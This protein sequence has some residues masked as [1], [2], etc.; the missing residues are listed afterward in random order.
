MRRVRLF[1]K[2]LIFM[3]VAFG[4]LAAVSGGYSAWQLS[5]LMTAEHEDKA[6]AIAES[7]AGANVELILDGDATAIQA[8]IDTCMEIKGISYVLVANARGEV[9]AHTFAPAIPPAIRHAVREGQGLRQPVVQT[10][11]TGPGGSFLHVTYPV[12]A[13]EAGNVHIGMNRSGVLGLIRDSVINHQILTLGFF[14][15]CAVAAWL[16]MGTIS[17]PLIQLMEYARRVAAHDFT[18]TIDIRFDDEVGDVAHAVRSTAEELASLITRLERSVAEATEELSTTLST[19]SAIVNSMADGLMVTNESGRLLRFNPALLDIFA[20]DAADAVGRSIDD[21]LGT[22][23]AD[24]LHMAGLDAA[25]PDAQPIEHR[26][27]ELPASVGDLEFPVEISIASVQRGDERNYVIIV[28]DITERKFVEEQLREARDRLEDRV[29]DRTARLERVNRQLVGEIAERK[30]AER[31]LVAAEANYRLIFENAVEGIFRITPDG[32]CTEANP[33][34]ARIFG[35]DSPDELLAACDQLVGNSRLDVESAQEFL[36]TLRANGEV[37]NH[38]S[39]AMRRD[40]RV[41]W[42]SLNARAIRDEHGNAVHFEGSVEDI[43][44]RR[45]SEAAL[46]HRAFHDPLTA[47]PNRSLFLNHLEMAMKRTRRSP[48]YL[49]SVLYMDLDRFK[50]INDSLGHNVGDLLLCHVSQTLT[51]CV[52]DVDTVSRFGGDEFAVLIE[53]IID[54]RECI[55]I[56]KRILDEIRRPVILGGCEVLTAA[57]IGIVLLTEDYDSAED[58]LRDADTAMYRAKELGKGHFKVFNQKMHDQALRQMQM[59]NDLRQAVE[60]DGFEIH[61]QPIVAMD[62]GTVRALE[63]RIRW[64]HTEL[65]LLSPRDFLSLAEDTGLILPMGEWMMRHV[66]EQIHDWH[67]RCGLDMPVGI[68]LSARQFMQPTLPAD[69]RDVLHATGVPPRLVILEIP[70]SVLMHNLATSTALLGKLRELGVG[71]ALIDYG[72]GMSSLSHLLQFRLDAIRIHS[73]LVARIDQDAEVCAL[74]RSIVD[75]TRNIGVCG[76]A[77]GVLRRTQA[78]I[79]HQFQC[80]YVQG[81]LFGKPMPADRIPSFLHPDSAEVRSASS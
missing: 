55:K 67:E 50:I 3:L 18:A 69:I 36:V 26:T 33:A 63:A 23:L 6:L 52:R 9:L 11:N 34:L 46:K 60:H 75:L 49:F 29:R 25:E 37:R 4:V 73:G 35:Y 66:C 43:T 71:I 13:G 56:A 81:H 47:L 70:E 57:S 32:T 45:E 80:P 22:S 27:V 78:E 42:V 39:R 28:R 12:L 17:R 24:V 5:T 31:A 1:S 19:V 61:Y 30:E 41:I 58:I 72:S 21:L 15:I 20:L 2:A 74:V 62:T 76:V 68:I 54:P 59:E 77:S 44:E 79:L 10:L 40:G 48:G 16:F 51:R 7:I 14:F 8:A 38:H 53:D 64:R 65:G